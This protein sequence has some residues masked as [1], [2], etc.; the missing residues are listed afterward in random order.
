MRHCIFVNHLV[1]DIL[2]KDVNMKR[3]KA[4]QITY[5]ASRA[6]THMNTGRLKHIYRGGSR[7][8]GAIQTLI[9]LTV[10]MAKSSKA[11][12]NSIYIYI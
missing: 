1:I 11:L 2:S 6:R 4:Q 7:L 8:Y 3:K 9:S 5:L 10:H 12:H